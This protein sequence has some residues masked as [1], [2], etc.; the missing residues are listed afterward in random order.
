MI[1]GLMQNKE[2][3]KKLSQIWRILPFKKVLKDSSG[4]NLKI[5]TTDTLEEGLIPVIDQGKKFIAGYTNKKNSAVKA[6]LP[7][8]VF[9]DHTRNLKYIDFDFAMGADGTKVLEV[10]NE[11]AYPKFIFYYLLSINIVNTGYNRHFK[12]VKDLV[13]PLPP[14]ETQ[15]YIAAILDDAAALRDK[16]AQLLKEYDLL[17]QSIFLEMFGDPVTNPKGFE[18]GIIRDLVVEA[19][20]GTSSKAN[21]EGEYPYLRMNNIT[22][23]GYMN[24]EHLKYVDIKEKDLHKYIVKKGDIL[25]NRTNSK[26]LVGKT[27]VFNSDTKM[28]AAG[29]LIRV[30][31]NE[32]GNPF[33]VWGYLNSKYGKLVLNNMCKSIVGM[34]NI[35]AQ[36]LQ[37]IKILLPPTHLQN[38][39]AEKIALI[40]QQ[41]ELAKQELKE[42]EDLFNCLL[43]KAFKGELVS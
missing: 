17:A 20:Y 3:I 32:K 14:L 2:V 9:G 43:Q 26:E 33:Y 12:F 36:E 5:K 35:N 11:A 15:Q 41:K 25:F 30:R 16:T 38:Q 31:L 23:S 29:Y 4:G 21:D 1:V 13:F 40:E 19:K 28:I 27:A 34:A 39:F 7:L 6:K 24:F 37:N 8:M 42:S 10:I 18:K 22:Y